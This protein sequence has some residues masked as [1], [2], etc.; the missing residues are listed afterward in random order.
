MGSYAN[1]T[2]AK[3]LAKYMLEEEGQ[4]TKPKQEQT[5]IKIPHKWE[6]GA[7]SQAT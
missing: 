4:I 2:P 7:S 3:V 1:F 6:C 5:V